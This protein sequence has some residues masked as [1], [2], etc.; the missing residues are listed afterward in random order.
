MT[1]EKLL[2]AECDK[3]GARLPGYGPGDHAFVDLT[4]RKPTMFSL[5]R[6]K[7]NKTCLWR[8]G[9]SSCSDLRGQGSPCLLEGQSGSTHPSPTCL[10]LIQEGNK[11]GGTVTWSLPQDREAAKDRDLW[12]AISLLMPAPPPPPPPELCCN[13]NNR[14]PGKRCKAQTLL[15]KVFEK[16]QSNRSD[17]NRETAENGSFCCLKGDVDLA[18]PTAKGV[19]P[20]FTVPFTS[21]PI[22]WHVMSGS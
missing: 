18:Q 11:T 3:P 16:P 6:S 14:L 13:N 19:G 2:G 15:K 20:H 9:V 8:G 21:D 4:S 7:E 12:A 17:K 5:W 1:T 22:P 10:P